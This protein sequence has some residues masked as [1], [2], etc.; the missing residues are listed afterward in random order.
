M[1][2][3]D[4]IRSV[5]RQHTKLQA[6]YAMAYTVVE[7]LAASLFVAG[8]LLFLDEST[9]TLGTYAFLAGSICFGLRPTIRLVRE[10]HYLRLGRVEKVAEQSDP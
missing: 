10:V 5:S 1:D 4:V 3:D 9:T 6:M 2:R 8:S 7:I